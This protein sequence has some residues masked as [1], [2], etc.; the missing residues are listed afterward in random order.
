MCRVSNFLCCIDPIV[1]GLLLG[2]SHFAIGI[3]GFLGTVIASLLV[4]AKYPSILYFT[5][6]VALLL[7]FF[8]WSIC[9]WSLI[10]GVSYCEAKKIRRFKFFTFFLPSFEVHRSCRYF[11][12]N[13]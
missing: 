8:I 9:S 2:Y 12:Y 1:G 6:F 7:L 3:V 4:L 10:K 11:V 5:F 13:L